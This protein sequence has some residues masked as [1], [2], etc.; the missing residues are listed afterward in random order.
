V[1]N[2]KFGVHVLYFWSPH[3]SVW[4][5]PFGWTRRLNYT[6]Q[7]TAESQM[8]YNYAIVRSYRRGHHPQRCRLPESRWRCKCGFVWPPAI[9]VVYHHNSP[10]SI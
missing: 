10:R 1:Y 9:A 7:N 6:I 5:P 2:A 3:L 8:L 4:T